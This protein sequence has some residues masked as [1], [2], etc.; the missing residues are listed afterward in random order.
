VNWLDLLQWPA[1]ILTVAGAWFVGSKRAGRRRLGFWVYLSSN[2]AWV[3]WGVPA[4][5]YA[6]VALQVFL[7]A[8]NVRG[9]VKADPDALSRET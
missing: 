1:A 9:M 2:L 7:A 3:A 6:V 8:L 4:A 5:A